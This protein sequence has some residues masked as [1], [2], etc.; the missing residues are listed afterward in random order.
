MANRQHGLHLWTAHETRFLRE[1]YPNS[2]YRPIADGH[3]YICAIDENERF[4]APRYRKWIP[5]GMAEG[6]LKSSLDSR[7]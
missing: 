1:S 6:S 5:L 7:R 2:G 3:G 4:T